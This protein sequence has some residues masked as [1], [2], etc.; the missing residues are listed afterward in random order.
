M[1]PDGAGDDVAAP[2]APPNKED[3]VDDDANGLFAAFGNSEG[4]AAVAVVEAGAGVSFPDATGAANEA[5]NELPDA[6]AL[7]PKLGTGGAT[8][9]ASPPPASRRHPG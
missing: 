8:D 1:P 9:L 7:T 5:N 4:A 2:P 3:G 6:G